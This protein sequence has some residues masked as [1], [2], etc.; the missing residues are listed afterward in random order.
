MRRSHI[1]FAVIAFIVISFVSFAPAQKLNNNAGNTAPAASPVKLTLPLKEGSLRFAVIG[2]TGSGSQNQRD[3][4]DMMVKYRQAFPFDFVLMM[5]D[6]L[7][8]SESPRD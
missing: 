3:V 8:G 1:N 6:N 4:G 5:G 7:Y 2:D